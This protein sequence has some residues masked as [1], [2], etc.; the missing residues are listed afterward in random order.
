MRELNRERDAAADLPRLL[1]RDDLESLGP[2]QTRVTLTYDWSKVPAEIRENIP[3][4]AFPVS[5]LDNSLA[6]LGKLATV[7]A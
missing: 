3:F 4:P 7:R 6:N 1:Q 5:H 2:E